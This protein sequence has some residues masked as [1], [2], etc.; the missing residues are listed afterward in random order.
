MLSWSQT[1]YHFHVYG[2]NQEKKN[3]FWTDIVIDVIFYETHL[4]KWQVVNEIQLNF[5]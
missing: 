4:K 1:T 5:N 2:Q 3:V